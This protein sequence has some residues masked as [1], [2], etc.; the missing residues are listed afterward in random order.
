MKG[1]AISPEVRLA[2]D[3]QVNR[4]LRNSAL[5]GIPSSALLALIIG[6]S[7][8]L[9]NRVAFVLLVSFADIATFIGSVRYLARRKR[10]EVLRHYWFGPFSTALIGLA[11]SS[12][13]VIALPDARHTDLRA[14]YLLF[15][16]GV[17]ATYVVGA[18]ARRLYYYSCQ[19]PM[20]GVVAVTFFLSGDRV[21]GVARGSRCRSTSA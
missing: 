9:A 7:V 10:G 1:S 16:V 21:H 20:L 18:A 12:M 8:P 13:A 19:I 4:A 3:D 6:D 2:C 17:S 15:V 11:W 14:V 5:I